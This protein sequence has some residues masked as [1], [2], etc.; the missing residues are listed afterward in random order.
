MHAGTPE[1]GEVAAPLAGV[2]SGTKMP[3]G[4][5]GGAKVLFSFTTA[6]LNNCTSYEF[7]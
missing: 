6:N 2:R 7:R 5:G 1:L 4:G 3:F